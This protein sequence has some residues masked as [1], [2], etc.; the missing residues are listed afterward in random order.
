MLQ[1]ALFSRGAARTVEASPVE[2][3][4]AWVAHVPSGFVYSSRGAAFSAPQAFFASRLI[5]LAFC[6][7]L[8]SRVFCQ[9]RLKACDLQTN[10]APD[11]FR[12]VFLHTKAFANI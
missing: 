11:L 7:T 4:Y 9:T 5:E 2:E 8:A 3:A 6:K 1:R 10:E 12:S